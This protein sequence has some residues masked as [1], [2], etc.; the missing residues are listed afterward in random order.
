MLHSVGDAPRPFGLFNS[1]GAGR[2][3]RTDMRPPR[4]LLPS[5]FS[6]RPNFMNHD[7]YDLKLKPSKKKQFS[8]VD[9]SA[10][11][12]MKNAV[13][14]EKQCELQ[15]TLIIGTLNAH[16]GLGLRG[17]NLVRLSVVNNDDKS[18]VRGLKTRTRAIARVIRTRN[19]LFPR[20]LTGGRARTLGS[21]L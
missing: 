11:A 1:L 16:G 13:S 3:L 17:P 18:R 4:R 9:R 6:A 14:C 21:N 15:N 20:Q 7:M 2:G 12:P 19:Q 10:R 5:F 8:V